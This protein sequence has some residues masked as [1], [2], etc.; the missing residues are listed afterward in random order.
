MAR[1]TPTTTGSV[2][3]ECNSKLDDSALGRFRTSIGSYGEVFNCD[4]LS[5]ARSTRPTA[6]SK[7][8]PEELILNPEYDGAGEIINLSPT[9]SETG[10]AR[11]FPDFNDLDTSDTSPNV[12]LILANSSKALY[13]LI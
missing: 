10:S 9:A 11:S 6:S 7:N 5:H 2:S 8:S 12:S 13:R 4:H 1:H 3:F